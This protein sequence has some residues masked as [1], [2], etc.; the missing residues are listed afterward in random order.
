MTENRD[1]ERIERIC[2]LLKKK[3]SMVDQQR[4]GQFLLNYIFGKNDAH[5]SY[6]FNMEDDI[7]EEKLKVFIL[8]ENQF[9]L[10]EL[11]NLYVDGAGGKFKNSQTK[12]YEI[13]GGS[14]IKMYCP[15]LKL[16]REY[17]IK[18]STSQEAE[19][20]AI[21]HG[22]SYLHS[23]DIKKAII[24]SDS[25]LAVY[26]IYTRMGWDTPKRKV[27][28]APNLIPMLY[29]IELMLNQIKERC[30]YKIKWIPQEKQLAHL[31]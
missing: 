16:R 20:L 22:I 15:E 23:N 11:V 30:N 5:T 7:I 14:Y 13:R 3:W 6:I 10:P 4:L 2:N 19:L 1:L 28:N 26:G 31:K 24:L 21:Q 29:H 8:Q 18:D 25:E 12:K 27:I 17:A 9:T